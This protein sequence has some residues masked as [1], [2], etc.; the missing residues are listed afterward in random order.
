[1]PQ[2]AT[3]Y[4]AAARREDDGAVTPRRE[5]DGA[6]T[7]REDDDDSSSSENGAPS[8][9]E[10]A[11]YAEECLAV[12]REARSHAAAVAKWHE[13]FPLGSR[14]APEPPWKDDKTWGHAVELDEDE[15]EGVEE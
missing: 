5:D 15:W 10:L 3:P 7:P 11:K 6:T 13:R 2:T 12:G 1:M 4:P 9:E 8:E 14:H